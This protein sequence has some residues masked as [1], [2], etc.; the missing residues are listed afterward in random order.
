MKKLK[1]IDTLNIIG[2][3]SQ[4]WDELNPLT[5]V[6]SWKKLLDQEGNDFEKNLTIMSRPL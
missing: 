1:R 5:M 6:Y 3:V 2:W 4:S